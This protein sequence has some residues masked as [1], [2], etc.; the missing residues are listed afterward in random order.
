MIDK[1][2]PLNYKLRCYGID[3]VFENS[4]ESLIKEPTTDGEDIV[5]KE[6]DW[7]NL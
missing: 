2:M 5:I 6:D 1:S 3:E 4:L 7:S